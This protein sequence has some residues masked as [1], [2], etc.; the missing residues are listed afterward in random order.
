MF[1]SGA[2]R[3]LFRLTQEIKLSMLIGDGSIRED[4]EESI[5]T[6]KMAD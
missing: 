4:V 6:K 5:K 2:K 3:K 1:E